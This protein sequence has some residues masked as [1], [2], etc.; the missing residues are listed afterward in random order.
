MISTPSLHTCSKTCTIIYTV[1]TKKSETSRVNRHRITLLD[2]LKQNLRRLEGAVAFAREKARET[3]M[4]QVVPVAPELKDE[5]EWKSRTVELV[6]VEQIA[7][8][9][10]L[11]RTKIVRLLKKKKILPLFYDGK[12]PLYPPATARHLLEPLRY[13]IHESDYQ[14]HPCLTA[15]K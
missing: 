12:V 5:P 1:C 15:I 6:T 3:G 7:K 14:E 13:D 11:N 9:M 10:R 8:T 2:L 4:I